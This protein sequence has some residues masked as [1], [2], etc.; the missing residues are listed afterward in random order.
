MLHQHHELA[1]DYDVMVCE[2]GRWVHATDQAEL[3]G[4]HYP[5]RVRPPAPLQPVPHS[6]HLLQS[7][8]FHSLQQ[9]EVDWGPDLN[10][11]FLSPIYDS[12]SKKGYSAAGFDPVELSLALSG[13][14]TPLVALGG[15]TAERVGAAADAGFDGV[16]VLGAVWQSD[17]PERAVE[18]LLQACSACAEA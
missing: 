7:T 15:I 5:E 8:S 10:Y 14:K 16:A 18:N 9:L 6:P 13:C 17:H 3:Q 1:R 2:G 11:A 4:L 12:I